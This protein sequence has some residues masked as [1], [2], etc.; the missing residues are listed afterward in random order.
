VFEARSGSFLSC[1]RAVKN[2][3]EMPLYTLNL[4]REHS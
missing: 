2:V 4:A 1:C 3:L